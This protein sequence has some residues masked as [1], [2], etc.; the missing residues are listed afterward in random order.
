MTPPLIA[1]TGPKIRCPYCLDMFTWDGKTL[2]EW[3]NRQYQQITDIPEDEDI[4]RREELLRDAYVLCPS[5][6]AAPGY[7]PLD[8]VR[9]DAPLVIGLVGAK[10]T[11][12]ST[13]LAVMVDE[14]D[15]GGLTPFGFRVRPLTHEQHQRFRAEKVDQLIYRRGTLPATPAAEE[16]VEFAVAYLLVNDRTGVRKP[17]VFFDVGGESLGVAK[18][19]R[20]TR[21][22]QA[23]DALIFVV[24]PQTAIFS[25]DGGIDPAVR[26]E[27][28]LAFKT[29]MDTMI[30][31]SGAP[32][33]HLD[34]PA[35]IVL[36]KADTLRFEPPVARWLTQENG[37]ADR[38]DAGQIRAESRDVYA[39]LYQCGATSW[40]QP[41]DVFQRCTLHVASATGSKPVDSSYRRGLRPLRVLEPL[42]TILTMAGMIAGPGTDQVGR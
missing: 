32:T 8:Y 3:V 17:L 38:I 2:Y 23:L 31:P 33:Q 22:I 6:D 39:F 34:I 28:D 11:G 9:Y 41:F 36:A 1:G 25:A 18:R 24:D 40:L 10:A 37:M 7:L 5:R 14:I 19:A 12:K 30:A 15:Q 42:I 13:L 4:L 29:V 20:A 26:R 27:G 16:G 35:A 21:F